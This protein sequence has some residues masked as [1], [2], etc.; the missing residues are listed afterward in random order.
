[1]VALPLSYCFKSFYLLPWWILVVD[2]AA[3]QSA[4]EIKRLKLESAEALRKIR[5]DEHFK[6]C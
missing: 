3:Y 6:C 2:K 4:I 5:L 1:M